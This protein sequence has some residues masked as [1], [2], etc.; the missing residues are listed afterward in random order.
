VSFIGQA[1]VTIDKKSRLA[2]PAKFRAALEAGKLGPAW[3]S[4][5]RGRGVLW[6]VPEAAFAK[7]SESWGGSL[8][9]DADT[10]ALEKLLFS[11]SERVEMDS[12]GRVTLPRKHLELSGVDGEVVVIGVKSRL[13]VHNRA[14]WMERE[15]EQLSKLPELIARMAARTERP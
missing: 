15:R 10:E 5:P 6:L 2:V 11:L 14:A 1:E 7:L 12:A 13:E 4:M 9:P 8:I 3:V